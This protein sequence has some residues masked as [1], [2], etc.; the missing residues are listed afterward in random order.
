MAQRWVLHRQC[1][2]P[3][4]TSLNMCTQRGLRLG[5]PF[6]M[7]VDRRW[8]LN[9]RDENLAKPAFLYDMLTALASMVRTS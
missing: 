8:K 6:L 1:Y 7:S 4:C 3:E 2:P 5:Y 9:P